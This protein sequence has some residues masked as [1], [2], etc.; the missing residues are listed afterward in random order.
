MCLN[1]GVKDKHKSGIWYLEEYEVKIGLH[2]GSV[3]LQLLFAIVVNVITKNVRR[4]LVNELLYAD[5]LLLMSKTMEALKE[6][7]W[8][9]KVALKSRGFK[10]IRK[11]KVIA[12]RS[13]GELFK[14]RS[15]KSLWEESDS[16]F[17]VVNKTWE[18][19]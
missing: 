1:D 9:W 6:K 16:K 2:Q 3:L 19:N 11:R 10:V 13:E 8:N 12:S 5:D 18:M 15:S 4:G 14:N 7:F 17:S